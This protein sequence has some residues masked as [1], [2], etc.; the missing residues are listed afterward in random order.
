MP[1]DQPV[2]SSLSISKPSRAAIRSPRTR[3]VELT[4]RPEQKQNP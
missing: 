2:P 1:G 4:T 3:R